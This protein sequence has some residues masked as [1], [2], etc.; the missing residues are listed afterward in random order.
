MNTDIIET[1]SQSERRPAPL[2]ATDEA[3]LLRKQGRRR[4]RTAL[5]LRR[6]TR[7]VRPTS[8]L[9]F[10]IMAGMLAHMLIGLADTVMVG[11]VGVVPLAA[12]AFVNAITH[13]PM[14]FGVGLLSAMAVLTSQSFGARQAAEAGEVLRHGLLV[15]A[16][17]GV[18][19]AASLACLRPFL[20][21]FGQPPEVV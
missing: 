7:E 10:P 20:D 6:W 11:R 21:W 18:L 12:S 8:S 15:A 16:G 4:L 13:L 1:K 14:I 19:T 3:A 9:A 5:T 17:A 2:G